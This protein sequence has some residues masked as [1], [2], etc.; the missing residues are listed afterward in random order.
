V[1]ALEAKTG[2]KVPSEK[3]AAA[4]ALASRPEG[5]TLAE[6]ATSQNWNVAASARHL[7]GWGQSYGYEVTRE[8][9]DRHVR[10][11][12]APVA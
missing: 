7:E 4:I 5:V 1:A 12:M 3:V 10:F 6:V 8:V 11:R 2:A 9:A